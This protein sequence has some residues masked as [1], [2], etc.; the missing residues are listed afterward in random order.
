M[1][2]SLL[3]LLLVYTAIVAIVANVAIVG[4]VSFAVSVADPVAAAAFIDGAVAVAIVVFL[5]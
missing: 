1:L 5:L 2:L 4:A 3:L